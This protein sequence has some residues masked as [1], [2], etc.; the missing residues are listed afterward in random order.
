M[1]QKL[2]TEADITAGQLE[3]KNHETDTVE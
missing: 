3:K 1:K 2:Q